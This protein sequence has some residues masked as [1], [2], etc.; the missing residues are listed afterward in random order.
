MKTFTENEPTSPIHARYQ[1]T[2]VLY[3][4]KSKYQK[5]LVFESPFH[6]RVLAL[7]DI[8]QLTT[9]EEHFYHEMLAHPALQAHPNPRNVLIIGGGDG[10]T[11]REVMKY[12]SVENAVECELDKKVVR[13][14]TRFFWI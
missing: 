8:V 10:G 14:G 1:V 4:G 5:I 9:R 12:P 11:L 3:R 7:D 13:C 6:G 2:R